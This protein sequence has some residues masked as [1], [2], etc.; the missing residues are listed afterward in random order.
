MRV[1]AIQDTFLESFA[2]LPKNEQRRVSKLIQQLRTDRF[3]NGLN[4]E[5]CKNALDPNVY[6][7]RLSR[8]YRL[9][10]VKPSGE[11]VLLLV[12]VDRHDDAYRWAERRQF[13]A[14]EMTGTLQ[15]WT[16]QEKAKNE[17]SE[18]KE[19]L[20]AHISQ[21]HLLRL[22]VT[23][24]FLPLIQRI[25]TKEELKRYQKD[26]PQET[27]E[28]LELLASGEDIQEV[29]VFAEE[30]KQEQHS[31][32]EAVTN[33]SSSRTITVITSDAQ[34][35]EILNQPLDRWRVF[36]HPQQ[37]EMVE[38]SF[39]GPVRILGGA[40]TGKTVVAM[41]RARYLVRHL[42][43]H[44]N[45]KVLFTTFT[46]TLAKTIQD[47]LTTM[48]TEKEM[49][50]IEVIGI[51]ALARRMMERTYPQRFYILKE[52]DKRLVEFWEIAA[53]K[54]GW[55]LDDLPFLHSEYERV[56]QQN[57][58]E[59][60]EEYQVTPR[61]G[62]KKAI[63]R[64]M[65]RQIWETVAEFRRL[66]SRK[67]FF[68]FTDVLR[69]ARKW[70][71]AHP[72]QKLFPYR[73]A[74]ID[75]AQDFHPEGLKL[76][77]ALIPQK[78]NDLY[79]VGDAHQRIYSRQATLG[80]CGINIKGRRSRRLRINYRTTEEIRQKAM[81]VIKTVEVDNL[82]G[83]RDVSNDI[84][85]LSGEEPIIRSFPTQAEEQQFVIQQLRQLIHYGIPPHEIAILAPERTI[86]NRYAQRL[87]MEQIDV[88]AFG[89]ERGKV[90]CGT[91]HNS[92]GLEFRVVFLVE[93]TQDH[94]PMT[95]LLEKKR[96]DPIELKEFLNQQR[97]LLYVALTRAREKAYI[98][99]FGPLSKFVS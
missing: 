43:P 74:I 21:R 81:E 86:V 32:S 26:I 62:R 20:F 53:K 63:S 23:E 19:G 47:L 36:L 29:L 14:N 85:L 22:G 75:E 67:H 5:R 95:R 44:T 51:D 98:T 65:R 69:E 58:I 96:R 92:K 49:E 97:S 16:V 11:D 4:F 46:S 7:A 42:Y 84:S 54:Y 72:D 66:K 45:A 3:G 25:Q 70:A 91:M 38:K 48:C 99:S 12:W 2:K 93:V 40:G 8:H 88:Q 78:E 77:R 15:M 87:Q 35:K 60:W 52:H 9:I 13:V 56:I 57:G 94:I 31:F 34:L 64:S 89:S 33:H 71:E 37:K 27:Y 82:D 17:V 73:F 39:R 1:V 18:T 79:I 76:L 50:R 24:Q 30:M 55:S 6:S 28:Y 61:V 10:L 41:H 68:E 90:Q 80:K 83:G 59:T